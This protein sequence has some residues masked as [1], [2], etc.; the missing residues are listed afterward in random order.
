MYRG[1][2]VPGH[3]VASL[4]RVCSAVDDHELCERRAGCFFLGP[5]QRRAEVMVTGQDQRG[6][7][8]Q[9]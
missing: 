7:G 2:C 8:R 6:N 9:S 4:D 1:R 3:R 5:F